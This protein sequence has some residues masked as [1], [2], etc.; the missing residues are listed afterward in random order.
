V[1]HPLNLHAI[2]ALWSLRHA[3]TVADH[4]LAMAYR[5]ASEDDDHGTLQA[6]RP[7]GEGGRGGGGHADTI[8][9]IVIMGDPT[10]GAA[11]HYARLGNIAHENV[12]Q[13]RW[14]VAS[15]LGVPRDSIRN[16]AQLAA[17]LVAIKPAT[18]REITQWLA[19]ADRMIRRSLQLEPALGAIVGNPECPAC[20]VRLLQLQTAAPNG[21]DWTVVCGAGCRCRGAAC[22]CGMPVRA[23][24]VLHI[25][26]PATLPAPA[27]KAKG[28][29]VR[30]QSRRR[31]ST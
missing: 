24:G 14:L 9:E 2:A 23:D 27:V 31:S 22:G 29:R 16:V 3:W 20:T 4:A 10:S 7:A 1:T 5:A 21:A 13:A 25:W 6:W 26:I 12:A 18:A 28:A 19:E 30:S 8:G 15:E 17:A 11:N